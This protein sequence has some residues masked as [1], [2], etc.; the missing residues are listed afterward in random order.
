MR[1]SDWSSDVC[2][3]D[4]VARAHR[5]QRAVAD[6]EIGVV[7]TGDGLV[8][9]DRDQR[10]F[11]DGQCVVGHHDGCRRTQRV[12]RVVVRSGSAGDR[13][14][15]VSGKSVSVRV[16]LGGRRVSKKKRINKTT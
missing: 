7:E 9:G 14:S 5:T 4:L 11:A 6:G 13:K 10:G 2:S 3:S 1:I 15:V 8:E 12:D 16:A